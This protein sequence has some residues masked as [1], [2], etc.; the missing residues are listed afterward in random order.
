MRS[1]DQQAILKYVEE[2]NIFDDNIFDPYSVLWMLRDKEFFTKL[3][4][5]LRA[6]KFYERKIWMFGL[7]HR[8]I[9]VIKEFLKL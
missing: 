5:I 6:R 2:K 9:K 4:G 3:V 1:G 8:D 7:L